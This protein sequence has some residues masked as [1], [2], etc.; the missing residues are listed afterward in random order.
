M[1]DSATQP[2]YSATILWDD[3]A[4]VWYVAETDFPGLVA[5]A[6]TQQRLVRKIRQLMPEL[7]HANRHL[8]P[9]ES[10]EEIA[11]R[12]TVGQLETIKLAV[13]S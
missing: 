3:E 11:I 9:D 7:Y 6:E 4:A 10:W 2:A 5:E 12:L 13:A 1:G 8:M